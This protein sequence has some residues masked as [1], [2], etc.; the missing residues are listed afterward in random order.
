MVSGRGT[1]PFTR[2][3]GT[4]SAD[5]QHA[6]ASLSTTKAPPLGGAFAL[7]AENETLDDAGFLL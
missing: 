6:L 4:Q 5:S 2:T 7:N 1:H 3:S